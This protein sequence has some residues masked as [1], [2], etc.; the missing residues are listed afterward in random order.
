MKLKNCDY[1]FARNIVSNLKELWNQDILKD[2]IDRDRNTAHRIPKEVSLA[3]AKRSQSG[4]V[5][6]KGTI[7]GLT[8][9]YQMI[10]S[11]TLDCTD[12]G[13]NKL[14]DYP[15]P[16]YKSPYKD[17]SKCHICSKNSEHG[18]NNTVTVDYAYIPVIDLE[19]QDLDTYNEIERLSVKIFGNETNDV[20]AGEKVT[21]TGNLYI[22]RKN[23][24]PPQ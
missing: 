23:D 8:P 22:I 21:I 15:I 16:I 5:K 18:F 2:N 12:C 6:V 1:S 24:N 7:M 9:V 11:L 4:F 14:V 20:I 13:Y 3:H 10:K 17:A 19:L